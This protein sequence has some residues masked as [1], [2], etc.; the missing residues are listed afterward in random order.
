MSLLVPTEHGNFSCPY[1]DHILTSIFR[2]WMD[3][4]V[5]IGYI[6]HWCQIGFKI[7]LKGELDEWLK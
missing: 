5:V 1:C 7:K 4:P 6:C 3:L 2:E